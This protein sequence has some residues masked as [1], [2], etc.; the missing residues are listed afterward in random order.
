M[1]RHVVPGHGRTCLFRATQILFCGGDVP[2]FWETMRTERNLEQE[3]NDFLEKW[4]VNQLCAFVKDILPLIELYNVEEN[5]DWV[6]DAVGK[7][8]VDNVRLIRTVYLISKIAD[9]HAAA[10]F[11]IKARFKDIHKRME[12]HYE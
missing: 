6:K 5:D 10:L 9:A 1:K 4:D 11:N 2:F 7:D 8:E 12:E 3:I